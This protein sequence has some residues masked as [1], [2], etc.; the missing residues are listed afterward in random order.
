MIPSSKLANINEAS[1]FIINPW[2]NMGKNNQIISME[3]MLPTRQ[4]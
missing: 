4:E 2:I 1:I 3:N